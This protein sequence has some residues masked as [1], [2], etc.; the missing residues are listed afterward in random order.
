MMIPYV[1]SLFMP[2]QVGDRPDVV[3]KDAVNFA[4]IGQC[5]ESGEQDYIF[6]TEY[7]VRMASIS[8]TSV[9]LKKISST[10]LGE[11]INKYYL[12]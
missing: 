12:S 10:E 7:S 11:L 1:T 2:R 8:R 5:A 4:F 9:P 3:P 6:T